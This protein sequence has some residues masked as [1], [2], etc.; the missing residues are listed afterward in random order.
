M[1]DEQAQGI[2]KDLRSYVDYADPVSDRDRLLLWLVDKVEALEMRGA[3]NSLGRT[4]Q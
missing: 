4:P 3:I 2:I 1:S